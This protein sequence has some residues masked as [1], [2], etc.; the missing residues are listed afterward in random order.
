MAFGI[1]HTS[2]IASALNRGGHIYHIKSDE[3]LSNGIIGVVGKL[4]D[5]EREIRDFSKPNDVQTKSLL[6]L[7]SNPEITSPYNPN[8]GRLETFINK[9]NVAIRAFDL[10]VGDFFDISINLIKA[11]ANNT[12]VKDNYL[13]L[14]TDEYGYEEKANIANEAFV[15]QIEYLWDDSVFYSYG[16]FNL[17][18]GIKENKMAR[19]KV[20]KYD[21]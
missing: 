19:V 3:A 1:V 11:L 7:L 9:P 21:R 16:D 10:Q 5:G 2:G 13:I 20:V 14:R 12:P 18:N 8:M 4:K 17:E 6:G 15:L